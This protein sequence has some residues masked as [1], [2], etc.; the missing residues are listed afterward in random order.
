[1][2]SN[3][4]ADPCSWSEA[5]VNPEN[6]SKWWWPLQEKSN[7]VG[8]ALMPWKGGE[9]DVHKLAWLVLHLHGS[10]DK[11]PQPARKPVYQ[12]SLSCRRLG[13]KETAR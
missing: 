2:L 9:R 12:T 6:A 3:M 7:C 1:M 11:G 8:A 5:A 13:E 4:R 10:H